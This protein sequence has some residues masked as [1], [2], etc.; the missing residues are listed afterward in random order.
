M[1]TI[2]HTLPNG[3][4]VLMREIH[5]APVATCWIWYRVGA[6]NEQAAQMG[7]SHWVEH[8]LFKGTPALPTGTLD[9][10]VA[11]NG[12][13]FNGFTSLDY[14]AYYETLPADRIGLGLQ[15]ESDRMV[16]ARFDA[17]DVK[18]ERTVII[19]ELEGRENQPG[20]WLDQQL[21]WLAFSAHPY[22]QAI[23]W[24]KETLHTLTRDDLYGYYQTYYTAGNAILVLLGDFDSDRLLR[25]IE[26]SFGGLPPGPPLPPLQI[27]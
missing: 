10:L 14:T 2:A 12:G 20:Y 15:I 19:A 25:E 22:R 9:R 1:T 11:R 24:T 27:P 23:L 5:S 17:A 13:V 16:N 7:I 6:R 4:L 21:R 18:S 26:R 8:M 3:M